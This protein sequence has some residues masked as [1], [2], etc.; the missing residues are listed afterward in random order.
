MIIF[1]LALIIIAVIIAG[2]FACRRFKLHP[3]AGV[4]LI[5]LAVIA[6]YVG[7]TVTNNRW[8]SPSR[9]DVSPLAGLTLEQ[10]GRIDEVW[11]RL[12]S[13]G[14]IR[15]LELPNHSFLYSIYE[16]RIVFRDAS[17]FYDAHMD[18][19]ARTYRDEGAA[20]LRYSQDVRSVSI[21]N[22]NNTEAL[23]YYMSVLTPHSFIPGN[24][25][26]IMS[27]MR[28]GRMY[29]MLIEQRP[30]HDINNDYSSIFIATLVEM[31]QEE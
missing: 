24:N 8:Q 27:I 11:E 17:I 23:L 21:V 6:T 14:H 29:I 3:A 20:V 2:I 5:L 15:V 28:I 13:H 16:F 30:W 1:L 22:E 25:R 4:M 31:L 7:F 10:V 26:S 9:V 12:V 18:V 19:M